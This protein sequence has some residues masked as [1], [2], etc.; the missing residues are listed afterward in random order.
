[1]M[2]TLGNFFFRFR[3]SISP[4]LLLLLFVPGPNV[5]PDP[6]VA[7]IC[8]LLVAFSGQ[9][10]RGA[11]IGL[12]YIVRGG[13]N[14][15]VYADDLVSE[16][17]FAHSRNP[18]YVGKF[19]MVLGLGVASNRWPSLIA[20]TAAYSFMYHA[21]VLAEEAYL[22]NKFGAGFDEYCT[23]VP[24]WFPRLA[25]LGATFAKFDFNWRRVLEK[26]YSAPLGWVLPI[27]LIGL[28]NMSRIQSAPEGMGRNV[29]L[30]ILAV[31]VVF[32][33]VAGWFKKFGPSPAGHSA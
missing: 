31:V 19:L 16:G 26:E 3:T 27:V 10:I 28:F 29:L 18:L 17:L 21:V 32:W 4:L 5:F 14:H 15:R 24:R 8:G 1:M 7:A 30:G 2:V 33:L 13:R 9:C 23:Q 6:F 20:V 12:D 22:R 25:G 11:T